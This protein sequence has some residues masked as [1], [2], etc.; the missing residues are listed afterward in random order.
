MENKS[1]TYGG[2]ARPFSVYEITLP[3]KEGVGQREA[4]LINTVP[5]FNEHS[6]V[7]KEKELPKAPLFAIPTV[8]IKTLDCQE[9]DVI[10]ED[11]MEEK[12]IDENVRK[13]ALHQPSTNYE[14]SQSTDEELLL[15]LP[16]A[17]SRVTNEANEEQVKKNETFPLP[18][19]PSNFPPPPEDFIQ[20]KEEENAELSALLGNVTAEDVR[21]AQEETSDNN[22]LNVIKQSDDEYPSYSKAADEIAATAIFEAVSEL[23]SLRTGEDVQENVIQASLYDDL[24]PPPELHE[25]EPKQNDISTPSQEE[26]VTNAQMGENQDNEALPPLPYGTK[27]VCEQTSPSKTDV[28]EDIPLLVEHPTDSHQT[29]SADSNETPAKDNESDLKEEVSIDGSHRDVTNVIDVKENKLCDEIS[30]GQEKGE[31]RSEEE[32]SLDNKKE[33]STSGVAHDDFRECETT[34]EPKPT[35]SVKEKDTCGELVHPPNEQSSSAESM[36]TECEKSQEKENVLNVNPVDDVHEDRQG[37]SGDNAPETIEVEQTQEDLSEPP[38]DSEN[39]SKKK[40]KKCCV[41]M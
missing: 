13:E 22:E 40:A 2:K 30:T 3:V 11:K 33:V 27:V 28:D 7:Q 1:I 16:D 15:P 26:K 25:I 32:S 5:D 36:P 24:P 37:Q 34:T 23:T 39:K 4:S 19:S 17:E 41:I 31:R 14:Q 6:S 21:N 9:T 20:G 29:S 38:D 18:P 12:T 8:I 10:T 35:P